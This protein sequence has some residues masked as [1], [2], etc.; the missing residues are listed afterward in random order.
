LTVNS[1]AVDFIPAHPKIGKMSMAKEVYSAYCRSYSTG[2]ISVGTPC[3]LHCFYCSQLHNPPDLI[4][5]YNKFLT[6]DEVR[7]FL[8]FA[9]QFDLAISG[10]AHYINS[11]EFFAHPRA[12]EILQLIES[13]GRTLSAVGTNGVRIKAHHVWAMKGLVDNVA[14]HLCDYEKTRH[15]LE[16]MDVHELD[17]EVLIVPHRSALE[18]GEIDGWIEK[19]QGHAQSCIRILKP[20]Y[21]KYSP[22][23]VARQMDIS[24][25]EV[26]FIIERWLERYPRMRIEYQINDYS[27]RGAN[28]LAAL[29]RFLAE[30]E[31]YAPARRSRALFL[32]AES[33]QDIFEPIVAN[34]TP[35]DNYKVQ[36]VEN[37]TFG[38]SCNVAGLLLID[39]YIAAIE[40][41]LA[42][43]Y[44][45]DVLVLPAASF[46]V[47]NVDLRCESPLTISA[48][49][50]L[51]VVWC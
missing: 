6:L 14:L 50:Q 40:E 25:A 24:N 32:I 28:I 4:P 34:F 37:K 13:E 2:D 10:A 26:L 33:S 36:P 15:A 16:L 30:Y 9:P 38:G 22:P 49:F 27:L 20:G 11:G 19:L 7:H 48:R 17:Y 31:Q 39:D 21:T 47:G 1:S 8:S 44:R 3:N 46:P 51:P 29:E 45:P 42:T 18:S 35:F 43:G 41:T 23:E 12:L 5:S